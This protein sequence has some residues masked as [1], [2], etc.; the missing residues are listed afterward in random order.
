MALADAM[1]LCGVRTHFIC[2]LLPA[3]LA[4][5]LKNRGHDVTVI[6]S[7]AGYEIKEGKQLAH[8]AWLSVSQEQDAEDTLSALD[9]NCDFL[10]VDHYALDSRWESRL[11]SVAS[12]I[13]VIDDLS[14]RPHESDILL[15][16]NFYFGMTKRYEGKIPSYCNVLAGPRFALL[17]TEFADLHL[18]AKARNGPVKRVL[19]FLGGSDAGDFTTLTIRALSMTTLVFVRVDIVIGSQHPNPK[20]IEQECKR[21]G[22]FFHVQTRDIATLMAEADLCIGSGGSACWER[23]CLGLPTLTLTVA[24]NQHQLVHDAG[25]E[26]FL[27]APEFDPENL[28]EFA[29]HIEVFAASP[30]FRECLSRRGLALVDGHGANRVLR[31]LGL[32][33]ISLRIAKMEDSASLFLWRNHESVRKVSR[34]TESINWDLHQH[35]LADTISDPNRY[36]L[37][38]E[39]NS[40]AVGVVRFDVQGQSAEVSIYLCPGEH[41]AGLGSELLAT[42]EKWLGSTRPDIHSICAVVLEDNLAS[43]RLFA[44]NSFFAVRTHYVKGIFHD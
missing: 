37:I 2:R 30:L 25:L 4:Y 38:G 7:C 28:E 32:T 34:N 40:L 15:D 13:L 35:W 39:Q 24:S 43:H 26:G 21:L 31:A 14:D 23:C 1:R 12:S 10:V 44:A 8:A 5:E 11:R 22:F 29:R 36:L 20:G 3:E 16:Q 19:V 41:P 18:K 6:S 27:H 17:R 33:S 42:A 9:G